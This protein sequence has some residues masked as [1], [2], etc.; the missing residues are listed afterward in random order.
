MR[1]EVSKTTALASKSLCFVSKKHK[2]V[3][4]GDRCV[5][6]TVLQRPLSPAPMTEVMEVMEDVIEHP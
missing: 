1:V 6:C 3:A 4:D 5:I 2:L